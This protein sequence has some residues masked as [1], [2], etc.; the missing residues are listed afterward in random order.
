[1]RYVTLSLLTLL[2]FPSGNVTAGDESTGITFAYKPFMQATYA[3]YHYEEP[4]RK[5]RLYKLYRLTWDGTVGKP[6]EMYRYQRYALK[7]GPI[8]KRGTAIDFGGPSREYITAG[9]VLPRFSQMFRMPVPPEEYR[10]SMLSE[11]R[12]REGASMLGTVSFREHLFRFPVFEANGMTLRKGQQWQYSAPPFVLHEGTFEL[13]R[14]NKLRPKELPLTTIHSHWKDWK[15]VDGRR[16][17]VID[18]WFEAKPDEKLKQGK[19][20]GQ[21]RYEGTSYF[22]PE[23]G[24]PVVTVLRGDGFVVDKKGRRKTIVLRRK[25]V[26]VHYEPYSEEKAQKKRALEAARRKADLAPHRDPPAEGPIS[27][28]EMIEPEVPERKALEEKGIEGRKAPEGKPPEA[29]TDSSGS[30]RQ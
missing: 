25:E 21:V 8:G 28:T 12:M 19:E 7:V 13:L 10:G 11:G 5:D 2:F 30:G 23:L 24:L 26:L 14:E 27:P 4:S 18:F 29:S 9:G 22:A 6:F 16:C 3:V 15:K 17:A 20:D 1:M